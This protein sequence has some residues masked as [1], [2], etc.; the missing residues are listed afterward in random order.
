MSIP[1]LIKAFYFKKHNSK[2]LKQETVQLA[3]KNAFS[4][5]KKIF[6][7]FF[8]FFFSN[9]KSIFWICC[10]ISLFTK[11]YLLWHKAISALSNKKYFY[12]YFSTWDLS[13]FV[14]KKNEVIGSAHFTEFLFV[15]CNFKFVPVK[16]KRKNFFPFRPECDNW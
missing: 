16:R 7:F 8:F 10:L 5:L 14:Q 9:F 4:N 11:L 12:F 1:T 6:F 13:L 3:Y 2:L 15:E